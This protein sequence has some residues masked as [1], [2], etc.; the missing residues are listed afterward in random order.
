[1]AASMKYPTS[2]GLRGAISQKTI[3]FIITFVLHKLQISYGVYLKA[4]KM[5]LSDIC[6]SYTD[7]VVLV[8][9]SPDVN[10]DIQF[11]TDWNSLVH[12]NIF[13]S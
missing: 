7:T 3:I 2:T 5:L 10:T 13:G 8:S 9:G 12:K 11:L 6:N 1:M 4:N